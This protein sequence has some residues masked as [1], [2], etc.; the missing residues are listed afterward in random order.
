MASP[1]T[2]KTEANSVIQ[3]ENGSGRG[4]FVILCDHA[5]RRVPDDLGDLGLDEAA[6]RAHIAWDPGALGVSRELSQRL[7]APLVYPDMSRLVIDCN[8]DTAAHDLIPS[9]SEITEIPGNRDLSD[10]ERAARIARVH[11]PFHTAI[12]A[13]LDARAAEGLETAVVSIHSFTP[14][15]KGIARPWPIGIL[16]NIDRRLAEGMLADLGRQGV[17][18]L[19]DNEPYAPSDGVY[20]TLARHGEARRLPSAM[21]EIRN[22]ELATAS[23]ETLW[24]E[25]LERAMRAARD[26]LHAR[27]GSEH[28]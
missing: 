11:A 13:L 19:G 10:A 6:L 12:A 20:Y 7:D 14:V 25:R 26:H 15:Y 3:T 4:P 28:A 27:Q 2:G 23:A 1:T 18:P 17:E 24:A 21:V 5:S 16:S 9:V 8:R 22:D